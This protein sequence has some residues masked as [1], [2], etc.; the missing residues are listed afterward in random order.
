LKYIGPIDMAFHEIVSDQVHI[1][2]LWVKPTEKRPYHVLVTSGV[3]DKP[4]TVPEGLEDLRHAELMIVLPK[5]W[6]LDDKSLQDENYYWPLRWLK[7]AG[8]LPHEY[9]TWLGYGHTIPNGDPPEPIANTP[10]IGIMLTLAEWL[11]ES[12]SQTRGRD[13]RLITFYMVVPLHNEEMNYKLDEGA[14]ALET[15]LAAANVG[16]VL[17]AKRSSVV[18]NVAPNR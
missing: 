1:D 17:D 14:E 3:S 2:L 11:P 5:D 18:R 4:M 8:R 6:K 15:I 10:F 16:F 12:A 13:D 7:M 9:T